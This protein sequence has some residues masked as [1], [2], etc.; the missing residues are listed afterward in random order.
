MLLKLLVDLIAQDL[1][2]LSLT[3]RD[4][5]IQHSVVLGRV[6]LP[7]AFYR[8]QGSNRTDLTRR[9][10]CAM[11]V[12]VLKSTLR[13]GLLNPSIGYAVGRRVF[14]KVVRD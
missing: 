5:L 3:V 11:T 7:A 1:V 8:S 12:F 10:S 6:G 13:N 2:A 14:A 4:P 9:R